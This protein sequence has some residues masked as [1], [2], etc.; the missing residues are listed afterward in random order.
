MN[1][2]RKPHECGFCGSRNTRVMVFGQETTFNSGIPHAKFAMT[3]RRWSHD[4]MSSCST[5]LRFHDNTDA[6]EEIR[7]FLFHPGYHGLVQK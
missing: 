1:I 4:I 2:I 5:I 6:T 7:I 3:L